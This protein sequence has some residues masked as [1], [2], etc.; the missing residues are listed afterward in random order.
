MNL[1]QY[2]GSGSYGIG[3]NQEGNANTKLLD[4]IKLNK[5]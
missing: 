1:S 5:R 2:N 3:D 4:F